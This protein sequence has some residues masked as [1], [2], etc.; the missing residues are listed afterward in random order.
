MQIIMSK[1]AQKMHFFCTYCARF[2][3]Y[4]QEFAYFYTKKREPK[5]LFHPFI[6]SPIHPSEAIVIIQIVLEDRNGGKSQ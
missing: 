4:M 2:D 6:H 5:A 3:I 1:T